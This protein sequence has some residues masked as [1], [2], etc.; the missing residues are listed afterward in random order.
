MLPGITA[1]I[2][3]LAEIWGNAG[4]GPFSKTHDGLNNVWMNK[5]EGRTVWLPHLSAVHLVSLLLSL[6]IFRTNDKEMSFLQANE[7][8]VQIRITPPVAFWYHFLSG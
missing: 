3:H 6:Y 8:E 4:T 7:M 2:S 1:H 5:T